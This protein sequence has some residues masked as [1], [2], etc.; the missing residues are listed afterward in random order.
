[1]PNEKPEKAVHI[2]RGNIFDDL[3][4][5][6]EKATEAKVKSDLWHELMTFVNGLDL[7]QKELAKRLGVHQ[8]DISNLVKGKISRISV[9]A[10]IGYAV[11]LNL[12]VEVRLSKPL[13]KAAKSTASRARKLSSANV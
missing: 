13:K 4:L 6:E 7:T 12:G 5:T 11:K 10:L 3:G 2:T 9:G 1:M 8:P